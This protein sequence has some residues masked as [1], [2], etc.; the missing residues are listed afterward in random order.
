MIA[1]KGLSPIWPAIAAVALL[2]PVFLLT[3]LLFCMAA[4]QETRRYADETGWAVSL[5]ALGAANIA[6]FGG[7]VLSAIQTWQSPAEW[8]KLVVFAALQ[9]IAWAVTIMIVGGPWWGAFHSD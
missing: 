1:R 3:G 5:L 6:V 8:K 4:L 2:Q 9:M 7:V